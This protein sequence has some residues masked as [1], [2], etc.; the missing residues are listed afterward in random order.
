MFLLDLDSGARGRELTATGDS[1]LPQDWSSDG[2]WLLYDRQSSAG[3]DLWSLHVESGK[4][5]SLSLN[6]SFNEWQGR[7]SPDGRW[8]AYVSDE[9]GRNE[10]FVAAFPSGRGKRAVSIGGGTFPQWRADGREVFYVSAVQQLMAV[11][12]TAAPSALK[13]WVIPSLRPRMPSMLIA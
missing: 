4:A 5:E 7:L 12:V 1:D 10:V 3:L 11:P 9:T 6:T 8:L 2:Q 13:T